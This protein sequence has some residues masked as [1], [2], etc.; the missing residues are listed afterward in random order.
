VRF[1]RFASAR[2]FMKHSRESREAGGERE[3]RGRE[4]T[5]YRGTSHKNSGCGRGDKSPPPKFAKI[6]AFA[7]LVFVSREN[8]CIRALILSVPPSLALSLF[9]SRARARARCHDVEFSN[10]AAVSLRTNS[11]GKSNA[12]PPFLLSSAVIHPAVCATLYVILEFRCPDFSR[13]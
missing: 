12:A 4:N 2:E 8:V 5:P 9:L 13:L 10:E 1:A 11:S 6:S 7:L 3:G